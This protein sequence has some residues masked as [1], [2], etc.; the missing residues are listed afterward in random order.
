[1]KTQIFIYFLLLSEFYDFL[2]MITMS[3]WPYRLYSAATN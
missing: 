2:V 1:M 3:D